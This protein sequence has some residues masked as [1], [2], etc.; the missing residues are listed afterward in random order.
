MNS[1]PIIIVCGEPNSIFSEI[2]AKSFKKYRSKKPIILIA[3]YDLMCLQLK[4]M[5]LKLK[6]NRIK[7]ENE[8]LDSVNLDNINIIDVNYNFKK[9]FEPISF[10]SNKYINECFDKAF[11]IIKKNKTSGFINGPI[12][13]KFFLKNKF[14]GIT[15]FIAS[16]FKI[17]KHYAMLIFN[18]NLSVCPITTHLPLSKVSKKITKN[19][20][21]IKSL[22]INEFYKKNFSLKP[23]IAI[24]GLNPHCENFFYKSEEKNIIEPTIKILRKKKIKIFGPYPADT[25]FL[26]QNLKKFNVIIGM[27][28]D[29]VLTPIKTLYGFNAINITLGLPFLR[30]S[31]DHGPNNEMIG[32][33]KSDPRSLIDALKFLNRK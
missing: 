5:K 12:S 27:Y 25:I 6:L 4:K 9:I 10:K 19:D 30:I 13:K 23:K 15:E 21:I 26:K 33:N 17:K 14:P 32:K 7:L 8:L 31:P 22:I 24:T 18:K 29:Q 20:I 11:N 1:K 2:L 3:S 16:R 28:H